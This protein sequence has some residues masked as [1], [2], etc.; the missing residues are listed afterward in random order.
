MNT[1]G[2]F[3]AVVVGSDRAVVDSVFPCLKELGI[4]PSVHSHTAS[5]LQT[6]TRQK[7]DALIVDREAD[8]ELSLLRRIRTS[9]S[10]S[11][12]VAFAI[13]PERN[14]LPKASSLADF[15]MDK[16]LAPL[17]M[18]RAVRAAFGIMVH[19][20]KRYFRHSVKLPIHVTDATYRRF[21]GQ[22]MNISETGAAIECAAQL[23]AR[24]RVQL[25]F[26]VP[27][28]DEKVICKAHVIWAA[29]Q[30]KAGVAFTH[31]KS[32]DRRCLA[33]WIGEEFHRQWRLPAVKTPAWSRTGSSF[34]I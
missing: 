8:P 16:P 31:M 24:D 14:G 11:A 21:F 34:A 22:T 10:S 17:S 3:Q 1:P 13:V 15:I 28:A 20:R 33:T 18:N 12:A 9:P 32:A 2:E 30:S 25:E 5:A 7:I 27:G 29:G 4:A 26:E 23:K 6:L 19:E